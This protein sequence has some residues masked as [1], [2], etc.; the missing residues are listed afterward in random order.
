MLLRLW[1]RDVKRNNVKMRFTYRGENKRQAAKMV[2][3]VHVKFLLQ[4]QKGKQDTAWGTSLDV[5]MRSLFHY[6]PPPAFPPFSP[7]S[8]FSILFSSPFC[9]FLPFLP[10]FTL[11]S[12]PT[13]CVANHALYCMSVPGGFCNID[14]CEEST[15]YFCLKTC[16][17]ITC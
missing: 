13:L 2:K 9:P 4:Q 5:R 14:G 17:W 12:S 1:Y 11:I 7:P 10:S 16:F 3:G 15:L 8:F 6:I